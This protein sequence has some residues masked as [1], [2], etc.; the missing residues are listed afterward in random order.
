[1][2]ISQIL[3]R[4]L[5]SGLVILLALPTAS[6]QEI[7]ENERGEKIIVYPDGRMEY[8]NGDP[9]ESDAPNAQESYPVYSG[10]IEP[11]DGSVEINEQDLFKIAVRKSQLA[12]EAVRIA[13]QRAKEAQLNLERIE[14][15]AQNYTGDQPELIEKQLMAARS[16]AQQT[17]IEATEAQN[18]ARNTKNMTRKGGYIEVFNYKRQQSRQTE[19]RSRRIRE[20]AD[21]SYAQIIPLMDN[22]VASTREDL[23]VRPPSPRCQFAVNGQDPKTGRYQ[24][25]LEK[26]LLFTYTDDRLRP[27]LKDKEYLSCE[28]Y[29]TSSGGYRFLTL[30][31][32]FAYPNAQ[33][34]YGFIDQ[35]SV[36]TIKLL[37]GDFVNLRAAQMDRGSYDTVKEELRYEMQYPIDR[38]HINILKQSEVDLLRVFWSSGYEEYEVFQLDFF[39]QQFECLGD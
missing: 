26:Q 27:Y 34:A 35:N 3:P 23:L 32:T 12:D 10:Y 13:N 19:E 17:A 8:F 22:S 36:L 25:S 21:Q 18:L 6:G 31:F 14:A 9:V 24:R 7:R 29:L 39:Q 4:L 20:A 15:L 16:I 30:E 11:L 28:G 33:E 37:N 2:Q 1:M 5:V 38:S